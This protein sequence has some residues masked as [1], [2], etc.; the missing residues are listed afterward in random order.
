M[1]FS[2]ATAGVFKSNRT[3]SMLGGAALGC[4]WGLAGHSAT[5][6]MAPEQRKWGGNM[7][8]ELKVL[9]DTNE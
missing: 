5:W 1:S 9:V 2:L 3:W 6:H 4:T 8:E 7:S